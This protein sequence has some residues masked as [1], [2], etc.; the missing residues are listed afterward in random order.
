MKK[1]LLILL[2]FVLFMPFMVKAYEVKM[3][4]QK[5]W[6][7]ND[8][9]KFYKLLQTEGGGFIAYGYSFSTDMEG[10]PNKGK[11]DAIIVKYDKD[12]NLMWQKSWGGNDNDAFYGLL[13]T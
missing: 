12:G 5:S 4:W 6:G 2:A 1:K 8:N 13:Q 11:S 10:L 3:D 7:G 9:D